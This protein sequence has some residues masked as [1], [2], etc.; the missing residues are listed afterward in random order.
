ME[1]GRREEKRISRPPI[2]VYQKEIKL[3]KR[4]S[5]DKIG[6]VNNLF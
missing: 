6:G 3:T 4:T 2:C 1:G 5:D